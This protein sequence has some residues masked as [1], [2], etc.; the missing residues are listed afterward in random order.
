VGSRNRPDPDAAVA[1]DHFPLV[2]D[3]EL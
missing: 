3:F 2:A 1:S